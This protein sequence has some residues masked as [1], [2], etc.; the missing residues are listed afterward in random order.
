MKTC[1]VWTVPDVKTINIDSESVFKAYF[2]TM[3]ISKMN[4]TFF[5]CYCLDGQCLMKLRSQISENRFKNHTHVKK[6]GRKSEFF[7]AFT[8][9]LEKQ[10]FIKKTV[11][12]DQ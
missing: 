5:V 10:M 2:C 1:L 4:C 3:D 9:E 6:L 7:L 11:N 12:V 8:D